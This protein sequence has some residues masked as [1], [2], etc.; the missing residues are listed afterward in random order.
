MSAKRANAFKDWVWNS[1]RHPANSSGM[2]GHVFIKDPDGYVVEVLP[3]E[4][5]G[6][7]T[8]TIHLQLG[9]LEHAVR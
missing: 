5:A 3:Q 7:L 9:D 1:T 6:T 4:H 2:K 8:M